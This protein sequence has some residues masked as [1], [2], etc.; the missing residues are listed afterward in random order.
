[1][2]RL[3][4]EARASR[5]TMLDDAQRE[6]VRQAPYGVVAAVAGRV[7]AIRLRRLPKLLAWPEVWPCG[8]DYHPRGPADRCLLYYNQPRRCPQFIAL[9]YVATTR[10]THYRTFKAALDALDELAR[11][12]G[13]EALLCDAANRRLSDRLLGR[14]GWTPHAPQ[15]WH[16]NFIKRFAAA[17][18]AGC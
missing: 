5:L 3:N 2:A 16:R 18:D 1:M 11:L 13:V 14:L 6:A 10:G 7:E 8:G 4:D 15:R 9:K 12:K 17:G